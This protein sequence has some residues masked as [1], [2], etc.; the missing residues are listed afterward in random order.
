[1]ST[2]T[3]D[4]DTRF[5]FVTSHEFGRRALEGL[6]SSRAATEGRLACILALGLSASQAKRSVG[7]TSVRDVARAHDITYEE[8]SDSTL[9]TTD[10][11]LR[12]CKPDYLLVVGWSRLVVP[13]ILDIPALMSTGRRRPRNTPAFGCVGMHPTRLPEGRGQAP[14]P[15]TILRQLEKSAL[16]TFFL[17]DEADAGAIIRHQEFVVHKRET[18][19]TLFYRVA[20]LHF[21]AG[22]LLAEELACRAVNSSPQQHCLASVWP[23]RRPDDSELQKFEEPSTLERTVRAL[24]WPYPRAF[25][26][27]GRLRVRV[28][29]VTIMEND[30]MSGMNGEILAIDDDV[31]LVACG[32]AVVALTTERQDWLAIEAPDGLVGRVLG[33]DSKLP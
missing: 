8:I 11:Q 21:H 13:E 33:V 19:A 32:G 3:S 9:R 25:I 26:R 1:V 7:F 14:I 18:A 15:W 6:L 17:E 5:V 4:T 20:D 12:E 16:T 24:T 30:K 2:L 23:K 28:R 29:R 31:V 10:V 22:Q 27:V